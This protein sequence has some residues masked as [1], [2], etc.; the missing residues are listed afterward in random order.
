M[1]SS[2]ALTSSSYYNI[3]TVLAT[4]VLT[5]PLAITEYCSPQVDIYLLNCSRSGLTSVPHRVH[6]ETRILDLSNN[7]LKVIH[8]NSFVEYHRLTQLILDYNEIYKITDR[9]MDPVSITLQYLSIRG[10]RLSVRA[11]SNFPIDALT[12]LRNLRILDLSENPIGIITPNWLAPLGETL[13]ALRL[14]GLIGQVELKEKAFFGLGRLKEFDFSNNSFHYLPDNAFFGIQPEKLKRLNL[15]NIIWRCDCKLLWLRKWL[16]E[17]KISTPPGESAITG[18]CSSPLNLGKVPLISLPL[19]HFQ[20]L[21]KLQSMHSSAPHY[22]GKYKTLL[23]VTASFGDSI[24][25]TCKFVSQPKM[26]VQ[27][28]KD[29]ALLRPEMKRFVQSVSKGSKFSAILT[30]R[31]LRSPGDNGNYTCK[32]SNNRG[33]AKGV[34]SLKLFSQAKDSKYLLDE[35]QPAV[36]QY[37]HPERVPLSESPKILIIPFAVICVCIFCGVGLLIALLL[38]H[39]KIKRGRIQCQRDGTL[40]SETIENVACLER[41]PSPPLPAPTQ[42]PVQQMIYTSSLSCSPQSIFVNSSSDDHAIKS[43]SSQPIRSNIVYSQPCKPPKNTPPIELERFL[44]VDRNRPIVRTFAPFVNSTEAE[45]DEEEEEEEECSGE[46]SDGIDKA[47][48][49]H[50]SILKEE[51]NFCPVHSQPFMI[52]SNLNSPRRS[53]ERQW[54]TLEGYKKYRCM[55]GNLLQR[56]INSAITDL[57]SMKY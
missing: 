31:A 37:S 22:F 16:G 49:V 28:Y 4:L 48:P 50:G 27:W 5:P 42:F 36:S 47:C 17:L 53:S 11:F 24:T 54:S 9:A 23:H 1:P 19:T 25:L 10:N 56:R 35:A 39:L 38:F 26:L 14:S 15:R 55:D 2:H 46:S 7:H 8:E 51:A 34:F 41:S 57:S 52:H 18:L 29:G 45:E 40:T 3:L 21:P 44:N 32:T 43:S 30:I 20:C 33:L 13:R 12:K 6:P